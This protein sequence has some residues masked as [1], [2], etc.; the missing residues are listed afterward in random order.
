MDTA[1]DNTIDLSLMSPVFTKY[2]GGLG[3][4]I[5]ILQKAQ[6]VYGYLPMPVLQLISNRLEVS[7]GKVYGVATFY[8]QFYLERRGRHVLKLC[9]GTACHVKGTP[10]LLT[11]IEEEFGVGPGQTTP[12]GQLTVE[13]VYCLGSCALAPMAVLDEE[14]IGRVQRESLLRRIRKQLD[15]SSSSDEVLST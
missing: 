15:Q 1:S 8:S 5:P 9:D 3:T 13:V 12:D 2:E 7:L 6:D 11:A 14:V 4:L 10:M